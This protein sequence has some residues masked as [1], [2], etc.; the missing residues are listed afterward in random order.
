MQLFP[1]EQ[2]PSH[3]IITDSHLRL[4]LNTQKIIR[5]IT[6]IKTGGEGR[7]ELHTSEDQVSHTLRQYP[8]ILSLHVY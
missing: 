4:T 6:L 1:S 2:L 8:L 5:L 3:S 7:E